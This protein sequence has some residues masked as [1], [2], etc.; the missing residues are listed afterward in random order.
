MLSCSTVHIEAL[1][2]LNDGNVGKQASGAEPILSYRQHY[3]IGKAW[4]LAIQTLKSLTVFFC[5]MSYTRVD[6]RE[7]LIHISTSRY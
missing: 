3:P 7:L 5:G 2:E 1:Q 4:S 6:F